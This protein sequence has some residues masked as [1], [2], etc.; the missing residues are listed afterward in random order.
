[1]TQ[2]IYL[3]N[4]KSIQKGIHQLLEIQ[5]SLVYRI[6]PSLRKINLSISNLLLLR[7]PEK[8]I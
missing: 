7:F 3:Y 5:V 6:P 1:M 4:S 8:V 2:K